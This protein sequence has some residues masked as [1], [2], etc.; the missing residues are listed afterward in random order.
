MK[1]ATLA[2]IGL[3]YADGPFETK[4]REAYEQ[5]EIPKNA[6]VEIPTITYNKNALDNA[7]TD[8]V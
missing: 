7:K 1:F 4:V 8:T 2:I 5:Y 3:V 6:T